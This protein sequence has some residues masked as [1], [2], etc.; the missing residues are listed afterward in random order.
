M[1]FKEDIEAAYDGQ[2]RV[3][4]KDF[5]FIKRDTL[6]IFKPSSTH[7]EVISGIRRSGKSTLMRQIVK[8]YF[9]KVAYFNFE[10]SRVFGFEVG[11]FSKLDEIMGEDVEAYFFD[12][13]Q[14]VEGW[15]IF[16]RQLHERVEKV[17]VT[18]SNASLLSR[19]MGTRLTGRYLS[20]EVFPFSYK[21]YLTFLGLDDSQENFNDYVVKGGFPEFLRDQNPEILQMLLKDILYRDIAIRYGI[22]NTHVLMDIALFL[23]S[24]IGKEVSFN[25]IRNTFN[26]GSPTTVSDYLSWMEDSYLLFFLPRFSWS[27]KSISKNP[28]KVYCIDNG[29]AKSN[30]LSFTKDKGRL[31]EN[32]VYLNFRKKNKKL[33]YFK[34]RQE[35][36]FVV[37]EGSVCKWLIQVTENLHPDNRD[38]EVA[39]L[40]EA[41]NFFEMD[42]GFIIT[43]T[44]NDQLIVNEK[45]IIIQDVRAFFELLQ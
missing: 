19:E 34:D 25:G 11:D 9:E 45:S 13:I 2:K 32:L 14:N 27:S 39:G 41:M 35:C 10:D 26:V 36:D 28:K 20:H 16:V 4:A 23:I 29:F 5:G 37:F 7:V 6:E 38:R 22:K 15:E 21:E 18:G 8:K 33:Y 3:L 30:S 42:K 17:F 43:L 12:E 31:L 40:V 1:V 24:N 44:Q